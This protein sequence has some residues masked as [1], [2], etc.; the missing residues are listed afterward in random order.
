MGVSSPKLELV[1]EAAPIS[2]ENMVVA[3]PKLPITIWTAS[4][5]S[6]WRSFLTTSTNKRFDDYT[7]MT[8][9]PRV[10]MVLHSHSRDHNRP[11]GHSGSWAFVM[12]ESASRG[13]FTQRIWVPIHHFLRCIRMLR[14][15][16]KL[17]KYNQIYFV[18]ISQ[19]RSCREVWAICGTWGVEIGWNMPH[20]GD[21]W[22]DLRGNGWWIYEA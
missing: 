22:P 1:I 14:S 12:Y 19:A 8:F 11:F 2:S 20:I 5:S 16:S 15:I 10:S 18:H 6:I 3:L 17:N 4:I 21:I 9:S 13:C 7:A